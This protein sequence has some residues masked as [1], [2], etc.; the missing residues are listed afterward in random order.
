M[1]RKELCTEF[2]FTLPRGLIDSQDRVHRHG[3]MRLATAKD[4]L[5]VQQERKVQENPAYGALIMLSRVI[6]R[7]GSLNSVTPEQ[8]EELVL[9][10][11]Y[12]LR[13]FYNR[14]NQQ[15]NINIPAHCPECDTQFNVRLELAGES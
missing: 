11:I 2:N 10:D 14:I 5:W 15:S 9:R 6:S 7:L 12:Y 13:E 8:L 4:E 3:V 1:R